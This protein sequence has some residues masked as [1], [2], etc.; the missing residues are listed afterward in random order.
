MT[1]IECH[2]S[3]LGLSMTQ[4]CF[5]C[6]TVI[7]STNH[8]GRQSAK[9]SSAFTSHFPRSKSASGTSAESD[10]FRFGGTKIFQMPRRRHPVRP[11]D[12]RRR[13]RRPTRQKIHDDRFRIHRWR[14]NSLGTL[15]CSGSSD[16][17]GCV[18]W[19]VH[20]CQCTPKGTTTRTEVR[21]AFLV[22]HKSLSMAC[23]INSCCVTRRRLPDSG[24]DNACWARLKSWGCFSERELTGFRLFCKFCC[25]NHT[26]HSLGR[27]LSKS[28]ERNQIIES[29]CRCQKGT[30]IVLVDIFDF[31]AYRCLL[32]G[33][34]AVLGTIVRCFWCFA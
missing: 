15:H 10:V 8:V 28:S 17:G 12:H 23:R 32:S 22:D 3:L 31:G 13:S 29:V 2:L 26:I 14:Y 6:Q 5:V 4:F 1:S 7:L 16:S 11:A 20:V 27:Q 24:S 21:N 9:N 19:E 25:S 18:R 33:M 30:A 34:V